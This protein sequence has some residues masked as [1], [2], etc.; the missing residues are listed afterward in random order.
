MRIGFRALLF[1]VMLAGFG[2][3]VWHYSVA[4]QEK[5]AKPKAKP[6]DLL[7]F[8]DP[9]KHAVKSRWLLQRGKLV[10]D[11]ETVGRIMVPYE[12]PEE[13]DLEIVGQRQKGKGG[14]V[15]SI[16]YGKNY[17]SLC[18]DA[19]DG[20]VSGIS[21]CDGRD[22]KSNKTRWDGRVFPDSGEATIVCRI[23]Q[24]NIQIAVDDKVIVD[25]RGEANDLSLLDW[26]EIPNKKVLSIGTWQSSFVISKFALTP[27]TGT[28]K[29]AR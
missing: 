12:P 17:P 10:S 7:K 8:I 6:V 23:R 22:C 16:P 3:S 5:G 4:A 18:L 20:T 24:G 13:Y 2:A 26:G 21:Q 14:F 15:V 1:F 25:W 27:V 29:F 11:A 28:G 19:Y 9:A